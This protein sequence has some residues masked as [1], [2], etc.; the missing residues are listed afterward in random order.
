MV[1]VTDCTDVYMGLILSNLAFAIGIAS[2]I[3]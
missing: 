2:F 1:N 3:Q